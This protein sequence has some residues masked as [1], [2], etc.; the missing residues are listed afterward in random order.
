MRTP[1]SSPPSSPL[2]PPLAPPPAAL[3]D[4]RVAHLWRTRTVL[5]LLRAGLGTHGD[6]AAWLERHPA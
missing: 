1:P 3:S 4:A 2:A 5:A 6:M